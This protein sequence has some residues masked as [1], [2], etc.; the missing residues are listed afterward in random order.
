MKKAFLFLIVIIALGGTVALTAR[1]NGTATVN[2]MVYS[3]FFT[4]T[5]AGNHIPAKISVT[6]ADWQDLV[7]VTT[8]QP[9]Y[10]SCHFPIEYAGQQH[11]IELTKN[12][13]MDVHIVDIPGTH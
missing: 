8:E 5:K 1:A 12:G 9:G 4:D 3:D 2:V 11:P 7:C 10:I 6:D 13:I